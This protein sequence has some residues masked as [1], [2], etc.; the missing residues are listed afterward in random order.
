[1]QSLDEE[2]SYSLRVT[3][4]GAEID[5]PTEVGAMHGLETLIQL[6][7]PNGNRYAIPAVTIRDTPRF[8]WRGLMV[9]SGRHFQP[10]AVIER[11]LDGM[12]AVKLNVF[13]WHL[14]EDQ[15]F[16]IESEIYP[17]LT[18]KGSDGLFY[19]QQDA[20]HIVAYAR[21]RGI[22]VVPEFEMPGHSAAWLIAYPE[23][24]SGTTPDEIRREFGVSTYAIDPTSTSAETSRPLPTGKRIRALLPL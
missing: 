5:A 20:K 19:T 15:G 12:A 14:T 17:K 10:V 9:D 18:A 4:A 6:V 3:S 24:A 23:L 2:E 13:H 8:P 7:Q 21:A 1:V 11:T 16:R 22:R